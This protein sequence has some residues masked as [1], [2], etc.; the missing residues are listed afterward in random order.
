MA[1][2]SVGKTNERS[3]RN[4]QRPTFNGTGE[5]NSTASGALHLKHGQ[6]GQPSPPLWL[7]L[8]WR[9][10]EEERVPIRFCETNPFC[11]RPSLDVS[12]VFTGTYAVCSGFCKWVRSGKTNPF[13]GV[14][15][16]V[17][18]RN[19]KTSAF[20][21]ASVVALHA[22]AA[23]SARLRNYA[24]LENAVEISGWLANHAAL[25]RLCQPRKHSGRCHRLFERCQGSS[26]VE[27]GTHKPLVGS[28]TLPPGTILFGRVAEF[29]LLE[30]AA[31]KA[32]GVGRWSSTLP[33]GTILFGRVVEFV[34]LERAAPKA[35]GVGRWSS[36]LP[37]GTIL[38]GRVAE[39]V[40][41]ERA[42]PK[43]FGVGREINCSVGSSVFL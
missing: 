30:R 9:Y 27:Q 2:G 1:W 22:M 34:L 43:A 14:F 24:L 19:R 42:A 20:A 41:L 5:A 6:L 38:F 3:T 11:F 26:V 28:S 18:G 8:S 33:P 35:F 29:V 25:R 17:K 13:R 15:R 36:T 21:R 37:P 40:L 23:R 32:F 12:H 7:R 16:G 10:R 39:F 4:T 31:P